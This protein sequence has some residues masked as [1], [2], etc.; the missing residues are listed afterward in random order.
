MQHSKI[1]KKLNHVYLATR[2]LFVSRY[3][4]N[5]VT[6]N[7]EGTQFLLNLNEGIKTDGIFFFITVQYSTRVQLIVLVI[8]KRIVASSYWIFY[9][10]TIGSSDKKRLL[11]STLQNIAIKTNLILITMVHKIEE[12]RNTFRRMSAEDEEMFVKPS[13][14][15]TLKAEVRY[16]MYHGTFIWR[17]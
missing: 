3:T 13:T 15:L 6:K 7:D 9:W 8:C 2:I 16:S 14:I 1:L 17:F 4:N 10:L 11:S 12:K 5:D